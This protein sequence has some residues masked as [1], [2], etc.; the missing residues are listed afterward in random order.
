LVFTKND[1]K[2]DTLISAT[3]IT[4]SKVT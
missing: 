4:A 1:R 3:A 2:T